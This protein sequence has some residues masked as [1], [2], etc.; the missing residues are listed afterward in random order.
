M[1]EVVARRGSAA[2]Q[3]QPSSPYR[4]RTTVQAQS[5]KAARSISPP[6]T[7][8]VDARALEQQLQAQQQQGV[9]VPAA[10]AL[11]IAPPRKSSDSSPH[12]DLTAWR[13]RL[14]ALSGHELK[15]LISNTYDR[16]YSGSIDFCDFL[17]LWFSQ[18][19]FQIRRS[20]ANVGPDGKETETFEVQAKHIYRVRE[21]FNEY[22]ESYLSGIR[23]GLVSAMLKDLMYD[24][25]HE[26]QHY[27][28]IG[29]E[30]MVSLV[31]EL[32]LHRQPKGAGQHAKEPRYDFA[33]I[34]QLLFKYITDNEEIALFY[35]EGCK[36]FQALRTKE[37][38]EQPIYQNSTISTKLLVKLLSSYQKK[39][40]YVVVVFLVLTKNKKNACRIKSTFFLYRINTLT[41]TL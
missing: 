24:Q 25:D 21:I 30:D 36:V 35:D 20:G 34:L 2:G 4:R 18:Q 10:A 9:P 8:E 14:N 37:Y 38:G 19:L 15:Q 13:M 7:R 17:A 32:S 23:Y 6:T 31:E 11:S 22:E 41:G 29:T 33:Y 39:T 40:E 27:Y 5:A 3:P 28:G 26:V 1:R 16:N 12:I